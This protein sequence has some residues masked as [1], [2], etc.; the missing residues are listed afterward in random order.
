MGGMKTAW[1]TMKD[2][3]SAKTKKEGIKKKCY[4]FP[5]KPA[6]HPIHFHLRDRIGMPHSVPMSPGLCLLPYIIISEQPLAGL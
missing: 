5:I 4:P 2:N 1:R 3:D 6:P